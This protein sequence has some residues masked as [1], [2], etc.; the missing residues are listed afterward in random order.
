MSVP[1]PT[2][3][4]EGQ[5]PPRPP[6]L[7]GQSGAWTWTP[8]WAIRGV[9]GHSPRARLRSLRSRSGRAKEQRRSVAALES[10]R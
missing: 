8:R 9:G 7:P 6:A 3:V 4:G 1:P 2:P 10:G 5:P